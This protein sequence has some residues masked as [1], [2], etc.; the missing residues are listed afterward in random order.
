VH[1]YENVPYYRKLFDRN[2]LHPRHIRGTIDLDLIPLSSKQSMRERPV[3]DL[4]DRTLDPRKLQAVCTS[5]ST[6]EP[7]T[8]RRTA[9]EQAFNVLFRHRCQSSFGLLLRDRI[10]LI[11]GT[12]RPSSHDSKLAG[13]LARGLGVHPRLRLDGEQPLGEI[14]RQLQ[15]Y[16]PEMVV[17]H[18]G[19]LCR[20]SDYLLASGQKDVR[21]RIVVVGGE[22]LTP[23]MRGRITAA[24]GIEPVQTYASHEFPLIGWE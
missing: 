11:S 22:V 21:P 23:L 13:R 5:G 14:V 17:A 6:G 19:I 20:I 8:I 9:L 16:E 15:A 18:P 2:R 1:A 24:F 10:A 3:E 7:F 12:R 4:L